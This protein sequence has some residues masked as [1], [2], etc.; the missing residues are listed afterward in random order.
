MW[1]TNHQGS[2]TKS[3]HDTAKAANNH[4]LISQTSEYKSYQ[5]ASVSSEDIQMQGS[6]INCN[7]VPLADPTEYSV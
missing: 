2:H 1:Q 4:S 5:K 3:G 7:S 6:S